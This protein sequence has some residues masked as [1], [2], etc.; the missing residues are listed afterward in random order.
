MCLTISIEVD[1]SQREALSVA[2][3]DAARFG[4]YVD[5]AHASR[6][7]WARGRPVRAGIT[8]DGACGCSLLDDDADRI[9]ASWLM[10]PDVIGP[11]ALTLKSILQ[12]GLSGMAVE[13]L[14]V[15]D[16]PAKT[17]RIKPGDI[18]ALVRTEGLGTK[19]RYEIEQ[20]ETRR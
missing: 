16:R 9:A 12:R 5:V 8:G 6:W 1:A 4:L 13:A 10:R 17:V 19:V 11:L 7:P 20:T 3:A 2:A 18:V 15:D 14:W